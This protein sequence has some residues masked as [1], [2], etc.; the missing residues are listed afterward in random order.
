MEG[1]NT[2]IKT[3]VE[4]EEMISVMEILMII[5]DWDKQTMHQFRHIHGNLIGMDRAINYFNKKAENLE[6]RDLHITDFWLFVKEM[7]DTY[8]EE[9]EKI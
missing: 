9:L 8:F 7:I 4:T 2:E 3:V 6:V 5:S 1:L